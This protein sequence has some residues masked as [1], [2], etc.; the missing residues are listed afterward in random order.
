[1]NQIKFFYKYLENLKI[2]AASMKCLLPEHFLKGVTN[3]LFF[4]LEKAKYMT[5]CAFL[6]I[7]VYTMISIII[8]KTL[9]IMM[10]IFQ[11]YIM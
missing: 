5:D 4:L 10:I 1:M 8:M 6:I 2:L 7:Y 9:I 11:F 3:F